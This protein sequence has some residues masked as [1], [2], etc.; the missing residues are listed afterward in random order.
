MMGQQS[1]LKHVLQKVAGLLIASAHT[2]PALASTRRTAL[3]NMLLDH[4]EALLIKA[5]TPTTTQLPEPH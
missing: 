1:H 5:T 4:K 3:E 2:V